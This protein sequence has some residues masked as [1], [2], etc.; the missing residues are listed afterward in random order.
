MI[1][2]RR[3]FIALLG[4]PAVMWP[5]GARVGGRSPEAPSGVTAHATTDH[6]TSRPSFDAALMRGLTV[7]S[8]S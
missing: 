6:S 3:E 4:G 8:I 2:G 7:V 5:L 1:I